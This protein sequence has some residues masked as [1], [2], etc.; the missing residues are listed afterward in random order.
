MA[1][2][3]FGRDQIEWRRGDLDGIKLNGVAEFERR[4]AR[5]GR[6]LRGAWFTMGGS[7]R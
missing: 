1:S 7:A 6:A 5:E 2:R 3:R 4:S